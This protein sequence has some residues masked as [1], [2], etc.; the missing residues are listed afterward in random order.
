MIR[1]LHSVNPL[2]HPD[3]LVGSFVDR[4]HHPI[5]LGDAVKIAVKPVVALI[6]AAGGRDLSGCSG[7]AHRQQVLNKAAPNINPFARR[8]PP[9]P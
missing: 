6:K 3:T 1:G 5:G 2:V 8:Q 9:Q 7:C 4:F